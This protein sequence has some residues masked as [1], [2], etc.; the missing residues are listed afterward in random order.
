MPLL[1][2]ILVAYLTYIQKFSKVE[3]EVA[4]LFQFKQILFTSL[5]PQLI[6][7]CFRRV[8]RTFSRPPTLVKLLLLLVRQKLVVG[9][10]QLPFVKTIVQELSHSRFV[11]PENHR[12]DHLIF[13]QNDVGNFRKGH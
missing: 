10:A 9:T 8:S 3:E 13:L 1:P 4:T 5:S 6:I 11:C 12:I 7:R 2:F